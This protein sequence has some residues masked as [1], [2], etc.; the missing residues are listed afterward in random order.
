MEDVL[1][2]KF[3]NDVSTSIAN[4]D[5]TQVNCVVFVGKNKHWKSCVRCQWHVTRV[6][7]LN[8]C[9]ENALTFRL[10][11]QL[12]FLSINQ[13]LRVYDSNKSTAPLSV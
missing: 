11:M 4:T 12:D 6:Q 1:E 5:F 9:R 13:T 3:G 8:E 10:L 7:K 2:L